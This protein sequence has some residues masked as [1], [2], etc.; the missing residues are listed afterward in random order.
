MI[1]EKIKI[2]KRAKIRIQNQNFSVMA[3]V[4][5]KVNKEFFQAISLGADTV[6][7]NT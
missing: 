3:L 2:D 5:D 4:V 6:D 7:L 1:A